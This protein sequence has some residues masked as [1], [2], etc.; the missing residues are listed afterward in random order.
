L[1]IGP[2][3]I[4]DHANH[5]GRI[6]LGEHRATEQ[7]NKQSYSA[8]ISYDVNHHEACNQNR[9]PTKGDEDAS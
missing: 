6:G 4:S 8:H 5:R 7:N 9:R 2:D 1:A 3:C